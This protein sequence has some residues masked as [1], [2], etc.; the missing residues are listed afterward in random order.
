LHF[1]LSKGIEVLPN[2]L[3]EINDMRQVPRWL[4]QWR[5]SAQAT[6]NLYINIEQV[7]VGS[8]LRAFVPT[9]GK[10]PHPTLVDGYYNLDISA[11][12]RLGKNANFFMKVFNAFDAKYGGID[13]TGLDV[14]LVYNP[15][16]GRSFQFGINF[17]MD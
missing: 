8:W 14:D 4:I 2:N 13:A 6:K 9:F 1:N 3:G 15:Q 16:L 12:Y 7:G 5:I 10:T 11:S 17:M